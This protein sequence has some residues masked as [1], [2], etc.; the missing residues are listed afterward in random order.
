VSRYA[1]AHSAEGSAPL[2]A[3]AGKQGFDC[4]EAEVLNAIQK[5]TASGELTDTDRSLSPAA[6]TPE[7]K[8]GGWP[9]STITMSL[10]AASVIASRLYDA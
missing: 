3:L 9:I 4:T 7:V 1:P 6:G 5:I 10:D 8:A 2:V